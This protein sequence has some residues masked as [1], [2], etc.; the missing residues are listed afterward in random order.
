[1][2]HIFNILLLNGP[3]LNLLGMREPDIYGKIT[4]SELLK[5]LNKK[6]EKLNIKLHHLQSN[7]EHI[8]IERIHQAKE[9][10]DYIIINPGSFTHTSIALRDALLSVNIPFI[11]VHISNIHAREQF[12]SNSWFSDI[13]SGVVSGFGLDGYFWSLQ[14]A[15]KRIKNIN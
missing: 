10:I 7:A 11:E 13:S 1:M 15:V 14:S 2:T 4:L 8:L 6:A 5:K 3:N 9:N 12:R